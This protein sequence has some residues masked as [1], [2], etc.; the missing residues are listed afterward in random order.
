[1]ADI[2]DEA[3]DLTDLTIQHAL[4]NRKPPM[5]SRVNFAIATSQLAWVI[6]AMNSAAM[7][8]KR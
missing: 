5:I 8:T 4:A 6:I 3:N 7:M 2:I 1:M